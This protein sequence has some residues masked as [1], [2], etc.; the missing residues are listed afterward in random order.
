M[1]STPPRCRSRAP[2]RKWRERGLAADNPYMR[3]AERP[4]C[5]RDAPAILRR[6]VR[7][8]AWTLALTAALAAGCMQ[9]PPAALRTASAP[10]RYFGD[11]TPPA[12]NVFRYNNGAEPETFDPGLA[13]GQPDGRVCRA[14]FEGLTVPDPKTLAPLPGQAERWETS[15]DGLVYTFHLRPGLEWSD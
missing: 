13:V 12:G 14:I 5:P 3:P 8:P 6:M 11:T 15:P 2:P 9:S 10:R 4:P 7:I 1:A